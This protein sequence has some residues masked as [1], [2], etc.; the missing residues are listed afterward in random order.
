MS[1]Y[2][3][4]LV[5]LMYIILNPKGLD[6]E[7]EEVFVRCSIS[8]FLKHKAERYFVIFLAVLLPDCYLIWTIVPLPRS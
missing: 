3:G 4:T 7:I 6:R 8:Q 1:R 5:R 2:R